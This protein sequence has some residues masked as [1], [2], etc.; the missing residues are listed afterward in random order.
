MSPSTKESDI[1]S[2]TYDNDNSDGD[3]GSDGPIEAGM[4]LGRR[5]LI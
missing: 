3:C 4:V 5:F 1:F 2:V